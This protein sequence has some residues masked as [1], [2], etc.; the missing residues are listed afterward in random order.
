MEKTTLY[1]D[2]EN[3]FPLL[4]SSS[5]AFRL[6]KRSAFPNV[7]SFATTNTNKKTPIKYRSY[8]YSEL[9]ALALVTEKAMLLF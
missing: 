9:P 3:R 7:N 2:T 1:G 8:K 5:I 6:F 4:K